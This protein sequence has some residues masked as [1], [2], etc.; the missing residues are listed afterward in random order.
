MTAPIPDQVD[1]R[2]VSPWTTREKIGR[3]LW[4]WVERTLFRCSP[5]PAYGWRNMWLR[6]FGAKVHPKARIRPTVTIEVPWHLSIGANSSVGDHAIL[7]CLGPIAIGD[8]VTISQYAH[9]CAGTHDYTRL[10]MPLR[11]PPITVGDDAWIAA[12][13]FIGP[14]VTV[15][16]G[17]I[18]GARSNVTRDLPAWTIA[19]GNPA[20]VV[21]ERP[22]SGPGQVAHDPAAGT[23]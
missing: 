11:R 3:A 6:L 9:L 7:Y 17:C 13:A 5:R 19:A 4:Y 21:R 16:E 12:E 15:A 2:H 22:R 23:P 14:D 1:D 20:R 10:D 18:V 8:R